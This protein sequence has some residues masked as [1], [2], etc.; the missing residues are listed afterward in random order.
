MRTDQLL[1]F[2]SWLPIFSRIFPF[3]GKSLENSLSVWS[4]DYGLCTVFIIIILI[5]YIQIV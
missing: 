4:G 2:L 5:I 1:H 3:I